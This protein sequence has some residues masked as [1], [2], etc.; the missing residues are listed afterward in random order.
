[1]NKDGIFQKPNKKKISN[2][3]REDCQFLPHEQQ[4]KL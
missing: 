3:S 1:M 4:Y 2:K